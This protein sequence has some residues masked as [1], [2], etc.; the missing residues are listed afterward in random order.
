MTD[1]DGKIINEPEHTFSHG[2]DAIRYAI[3]SIVG[4]KGTTMPPPTTGLV[5]PFPGFS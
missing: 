3:E 2:M 4:K 1:R 5:K